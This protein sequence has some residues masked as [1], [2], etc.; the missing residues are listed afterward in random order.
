MRIRAMKK[1]SQN[2][3]NLLDA[4]MNVGSVK[5]KDYENKRL[6][7]CGEN[8]PNSKPNKAKQ[9]QFSRPT[10]RNKPKQTQTN[11]ISTQKAR[12]F[13]NFLPLFTHF[14]QFFTQKQRFPP[15]SDPKNLPKSD[16]LS[17][18]L[19]PRHPQAPLNA[20]RCPLSAIRSCLPPVKLA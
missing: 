20:L 6:C 13:A 7:R 12:I 4:Q 18:S 15:K 14:Y 1:Q 10:R 2:K 17:T 3:P 16:F 8:K 19:C 5:T 11:P 9:S